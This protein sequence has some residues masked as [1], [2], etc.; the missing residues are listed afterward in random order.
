M[1]WLVAAIFLARGLLGVPLVLLVDDPYMNELK[2]MMTFMILTSLV[3]VLLGVCYAI[4][5]ASIR[6]RL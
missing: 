5:A 1:L 3:C 2:G 6:E 4:G